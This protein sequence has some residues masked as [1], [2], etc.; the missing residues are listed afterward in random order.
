MGMIG[1]MGIVGTVTFGR[2]TFG[3]VMLGVSIVGHVMFG[4]VIVGPVMLG[5]LIS[6]PGTTGGLILI[7]GIVGLASAPI[8]KSN[9]GQMIPNPHNIPNKSAKSP[10]NPQRIQQHGEQQLFLIVGSSSGAKFL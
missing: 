1:I 7:S 2:V 8:P 5:V 9:P 3:R 10:N 4:V 6:I